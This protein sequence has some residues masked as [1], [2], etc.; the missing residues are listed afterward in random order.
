LNIEEYIASG[1]LESYV[2]GIATQEEA[3]EVEKLAA[4]HPRIQAEIE[5]IR[6]SLE[7]YARQF[8]KAP[9]PSLRDKVLQALDDLAEAPTASSEVPDPAIIPIYRPESPADKQEKSLYRNSFLV[10]ASITALLVSLAANMYLF[11]RWKYAEQRLVIAEADNLKLA[12]EFEVNQARYS[13]ASEALAVLQNPEN[14]VIQLQGQEIAKNASAVIYWNAREGKVFLAASHLPPPPSD[15]QYQLWA[16]VDGKPVDAGMLATG[17][18][19]VQ[20]MKDIPKAQAFAITLEKIGGNPV[21][22]S[23]LYVMG[24]V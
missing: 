7:V 6:A 9:P 2:L 23:Q 8:E 20:Q 10:A 18:A 12:Q 22:T 16:I 1:I 11:N 15:K 21:P 19:G 5:A 14:Q 4:Q 13:K 17:G 24:E 3:A